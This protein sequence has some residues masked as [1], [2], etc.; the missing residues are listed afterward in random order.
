LSA[1]N[2]KDMQVVMVTSIVSPFSFQ[3]NLRCPSI[4]VRDIEV[5]GTM[6]DKA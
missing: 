4:N 6:F 5:V 2:N 3:Y 1:S